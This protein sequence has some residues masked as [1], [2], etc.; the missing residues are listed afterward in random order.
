MTLLQGV[1]K[2]PFIEENR[3]LAEISKVEHTLTV[4]YAI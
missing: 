4:S 3:L 2:L 1:A